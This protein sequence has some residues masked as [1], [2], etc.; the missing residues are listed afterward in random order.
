MFFYRFLTLERKEK[1]EE[2]GTTGPVPERTAK[3]LRPWCR[4]LHPLIRL[5]YRALYVPLCPRHLERPDPTTLSAK[6]SFRRAEIAVGFSCKSPPG[7]PGP[8]QIITLSLQSLY[9]SLGR[10]LVNKNCTAESP[11]TATHNASTLYAVE[12]DCPTVRPLRRIRVLFADNS[13]DF[14]TVVGAL[15]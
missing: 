5:N 6:V 9:S 7:C 13:P 4:P 2:S 12:N 14:Q 11:M 1:S 15:L 8:A 3:D 10:N